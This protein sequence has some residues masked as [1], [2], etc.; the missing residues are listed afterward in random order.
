VK[1]YVSEGLLPTRYVP[2]SRGSR[3]LAFDVKELE[4]LKKKRGATLKSPTPIQPPTDP[5]DRELNL[6]YRVGEPLQVNSM[7]Q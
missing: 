3:E 5:D 7:C 1:R 6:Q 4:T 2:G